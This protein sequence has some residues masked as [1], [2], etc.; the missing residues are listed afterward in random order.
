VRGTNGSGDGDQLLLEET[1]EETV[2]TLEYDVD[3]SVLVEPS[4][5]HGDEQ[6]QRLVGFFRQA[7]E[8]EVAVAYANGAAIVVAFFVAALPARDMIVL[9]VLTKAT[10]LLGSVLAILLRLAWTLDPS[11]LA[12]QEW[13]IQVGP[14]GREAE[15]AADPPPLPLRKL[16]RDDRK[17][18]PDRGQDLRLERCCSMNSCFC[19]KRQRSPPCWVLKP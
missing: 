7:G 8:G 10:H 12:E 9:G 5:P 6:A 16:C 17:D 15:E 19:I 3:S 1:E 13:S 2:A 4:E 18:V 14:F 11:D